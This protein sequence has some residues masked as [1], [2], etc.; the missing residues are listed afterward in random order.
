[1]RLSTEQLR[2]VHSDFAFTFL[3]FVD[4]GGAVGSDHVVVLVGSIIPLGNKDEPRLNAEGGG[5]TAL[6]GQF[7]NHFGG[8]AFGPNPLSG[9]DPLVLSTRK[10]EV[11]VAIGFLLDGECSARG[12]GVE[13]VWAHGIQAG[14][15][16]AH[17]FS[18]DITSWE[19]FS[20][21]TL[22]LEII[23]GHIN[24]GLHSVD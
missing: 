17:E 15:A 12:T 18:A 6:E 13:R 23:D 9:G 21:K 5:S 7:E 2:T 24:T 22:D 11:L 1:M 8:K 10:P 16:V 20:A 4:T 3:P 14:V 19:V